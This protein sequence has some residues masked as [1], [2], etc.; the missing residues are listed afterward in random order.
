MTEHAIFDREELL[1]RVGDDEELIEQL[2]DLFA[3]DYESRLTDIETSIKARDYD[4]V[5][6][7]SHTLKGSS[8]NLSFHRVYYTARDLET[9]A[10]EQKY[11]QMTSLFKILHAQVLE[12]LQT[13][14]RG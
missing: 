11:D 5:R 7:A 2:L 14:G 3:E 10:A 13:I 6:K 1:E 9:A 8:G 12:A 4:T